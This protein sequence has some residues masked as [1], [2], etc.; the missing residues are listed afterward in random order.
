[1]PTSLDIDDVS[2]WASNDFEE[3]EKILHDIIPHIR[4]FHIPA[5][6]FWKKISILEPIFS[7]QLYR[8]IIG[9]HFDPNTTPNT[10]VLP[11][12]N[13]SS[14]QGT[15]HDIS[16]P[17]QNQQYNFN[18]LIGS[19]FFFGVPNVNQQPPPRGRKFRTLRRSRR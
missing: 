11:K 6:V 9:Y 1:M 13:I 19:T 14:R 17:Q 15:S 5:K 16:Q 18:N 10:L 3:L 2:H 12:R 7:K 4:W 8:D